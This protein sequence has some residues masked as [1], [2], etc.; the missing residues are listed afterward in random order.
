MLGRIIVSGITITVLGFRGGVFGREKLLITCDDN[1]IIKYK[2][3]KSWLGGEGIV[4]TTENNDGHNFKV[5]SKFDKNPIDL[6]IIDKNDN[7]IGKSK[8]R[9]W[10]NLFS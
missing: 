3:I 8:G 4:W 5:Q 2:H 7:I 1:V 9:D 6:V 10:H